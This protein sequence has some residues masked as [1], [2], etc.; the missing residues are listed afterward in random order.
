MKA[1]K[2]SVML[3]LI[4]FATSV[5]AAP[6]EIAAQL[7]RQTPEL[8]K[9]ADIPGVSVALIEDGNIVW[10][11]G[12]GIKNADTREP[13]DDRTVF[14]VASLSKPVFAVAVLHLVD[15]GKLNLDEPLSTY[16][17][18]YIPDDD[19]VNRITAR[20]VLTHRTGFPNWRESM[21]AP[22]KIYFNPGERYSYSGEGFIYLQKAVE[23][24]TGQPLKEFVRQRVLVP[25]G[26]TDSSYVWEDRYEYQ[27][28][29]GYLE[30]G[31]TRPSKAIETGSP[32]PGHRGPSAASSLHST[33]RDIAR[34]AVAAMHGA[35]LKDETFR[36][37][38]STQT[39]VD[40][41]CSNCIGKPVTRPAAISWGL[42][43]GLA[44]TPQGQLFYHLGDNPG[45]HSFFSV[46][47]GTKRGVV[48][49]TNNDRGP[50]I[51][52]EA[53]RMA[54]GED[55][56][57][58]KW[59]PYA[60]HFESYDSPRMQLD[61]KILEKGIDEALKQYAEGPALAED[62]VDILG[63]QLLGQ[64]KFREA[65]RVLEMNVAAHPD[66]GGALLSLADAY[67]VAA[68]QISIGYAR[69]A[70][71][72]NPNDGRAIGMLDCLEAR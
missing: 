48:V 59:R 2:L 49:L 51:L 45:F 12:F 35:G 28:A 40:E 42:G 60:D 6:S 44:E 1:P 38:L 18:A 7:A 72:L 22:L 68:K 23:R 10:T 50:M 71:E 70:L 26:M 33:A 27:H 8:M 5:R 9:R 66:S 43:F 46:S 56:P 52:P 58:F 13:V 69:K 20:M 64:R 32:L 29:T 53:A 34:F 14:E 16:L 57:C 65:I 36:Q 61:R 55:H 47:R 11:G 24:I 4:A 39:T 63:R 62:R 37:M 19:R 25:F 17:P 31:P 67:S 15:E 21:S 54:L 30:S 41:A 3:S